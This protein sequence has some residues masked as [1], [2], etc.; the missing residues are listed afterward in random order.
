MCCTDDKFDVHTTC[1]NV[2][3]LLKNLNI[4]QASP[5]PPTHH[6]PHTTTTTDATAVNSDDDDDNTNNNVTLQI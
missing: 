4:T 3:D 1:N 5:P 6:H 2:N